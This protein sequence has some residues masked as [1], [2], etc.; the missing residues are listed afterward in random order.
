MLLYTVN[1]GLCVHSSHWTHRNKNKTLPCWQ[2][3]RFFLFFLIHA[4]HVA[5]MIFVLSRGCLTHLLWQ[6]L[7]RQWAYFARLFP[8]KYLY[9]PPQV[10]LK[11][12]N[13]TLFIC[14]DVLQHVCGDKMITYWFFPSTVWFLGTC[15]IMLGNKDLYLWNH[16]APTIQDFFFL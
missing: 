3:L 5:T 16:P 8:S 6:T 12:S 14:E 9:I 4:L 7:V 15:V 10:F 11:T 13:K 2:K 1:S